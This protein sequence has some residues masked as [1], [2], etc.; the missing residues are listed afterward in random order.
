MQQEPTTATSNIQQASELLER[1]REL[2]RAASMEEATNTTTAA[3]VRRMPT[4]Q[5]QRDPVLWAAFTRGWEERTASFLRATSGDPTMAINLNRSR[6]TRQTSRPAATA[7]TAGTARP[8]NATHPAATSRPHRPRMQPPAPAPRPNTTRPTPP[9]VEHSLSPP[10]RTPNAATTTPATVPAP[11]NARQR[12]NQQRMRDHR[13][14]QQCS[15]QHRLEKPAT[16]APPNTVP[17]VVAPQQE[18]APPAPA[19]ATVPEV[20]IPTGTT[21]VTEQPTAAPSQTVDMEISA[22]EEA[23]LLGG[24]DAHLADEVD[25]ETVFDNRFHSLPASPRRE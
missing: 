12:R 16:T 4:A 7:P 13:A 8:P 6:S 22:E 10:T 24:P 19:A 9:T 15:Q 17:T 3:R 5:L 18:T 14:R 25:M 21:G 23:E 2:L 20:A 11:L 1:S